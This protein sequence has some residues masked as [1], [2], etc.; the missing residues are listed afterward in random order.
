[1]LNVKYMN[2]QNSLKNDKRAIA[3]IKR[4]IYPTGTNGQKNK[5]CIAMCCEIRLCVKRL[6]EKY[7]PFAS[8]VCALSKFDDSRTFERREN[9]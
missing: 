6:R 3:N 1:M 9:R 5:R 8:V 4:Q 7:F 2:C